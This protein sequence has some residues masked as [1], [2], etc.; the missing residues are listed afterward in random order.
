MFYPMLVVGIDFILS[1]L[2]YCIFIFALR[3]PSLFTSS[4]SICVFLTNA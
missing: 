3:Y 1:Y 2:N 4:L